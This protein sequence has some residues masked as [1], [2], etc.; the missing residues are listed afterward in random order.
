MG[1][2][3]L[4]SSPKWWSPEQPFVVFPA[5]RTHAGKGRIEPS[6]RVQALVGQIA[7]RYGHKESHMSKW[8]HRILITSDGPVCSCGSSVKWKPS[9]KR[10]VCLE[11]IRAQ[12]R[13]SSPKQR[14]RKWNYT[15]ENRDYRKHKKGKCE[16]CG[17]TPEHPCQLDVDHIDGNHHNNDPNNLQ[18]LCANC[19]RLKT[20]KQKSLHQ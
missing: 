18:T 10:Y 13:P 15:V 2:A 9:L 20:W 1:D 12:K 3:G 17:F 5:L 4:G 19:H 6:K 11:A 14:K 16:F 8:T 7:L